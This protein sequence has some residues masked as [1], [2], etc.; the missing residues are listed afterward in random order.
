MCG[1][2]TARQGRSAFGS[3]TT[4][5]PEPP[6][7]AAA[8]ERFDALLTTTVTDRLIADV[9]LGVFLSGGIDSST[10]AYYAARA[11][12]R[13]IKTFS[14]GF[15]EKAFDESAAA[16]AVAAHLGTDHHEQIFSAH[17]ALAAIP[18]LPDVFDEPVA[19]TS[20]LPDPS[21]FKIHARKRD[22]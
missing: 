19:D 1:L 12:E 18:S 21:P 11:A 8:L 22:P 6:S 20:V 10:V 5:L 16:R 4:N 14:I 9:P 17:D 2:K 13:R 3:R 7:E 15:T